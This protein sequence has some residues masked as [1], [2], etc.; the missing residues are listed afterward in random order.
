MENETNYDKAKVYCSNEI[1]V[2]VT[3]SSR[4]FYNGIIVE[5]KPKFLLIV[6]EVLG[7]IPVFFIEVDKIEPREVKR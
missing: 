1:V 2:H 4:K 7:K 5:V 6:D 3:L